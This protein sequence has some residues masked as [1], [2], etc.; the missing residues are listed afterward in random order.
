MESEQDISEASVSDSTNVGLEWSED[1]AMD[2]AGSYPAAF[3]DTAAKLN[4]LANRAWGSSR[5]QDCMRRALCIQVSRLSCTSRIW[6][7]SQ[8]EC[9]CSK[10]F[11][12]LGLCI[13]A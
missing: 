13:L 3:P 2:D 12:G 4:T 8:D 10:C 11:V 6:D 1:E 7:R 5:E 9:S